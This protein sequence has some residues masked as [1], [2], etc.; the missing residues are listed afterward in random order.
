M[1]VEYCTRGR[2]MNQ[3]ASHSH[4]VWEIIVVEA[5]NIDMVIDDRTYK[6]GKSSVI[7]LPPNAIHSASSDTEFHDIFVQ[8]KNLDF[9]GVQIV[10]DTDNS[11]LTLMNLLN[12]VLLEAEKNYRNIA[13]ALMETICQYI[14]KLMNVNIKYG[15]A[16]QLKNTIF[17]GFSDAD[18]SIKKE[19]EK[20]GFQ[21]DYMRRCFKEETGRTPLEYLTYLRINLARNLLVQATFVSVEDVSR[22]CGFKDSYYFSTCFRKHTGVSPSRYRKQY[23]EL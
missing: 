5:G 4:A 23:R 1:N 10:Q 2:L 12:K 3:Y 14:Q 7:V 15:F 18:F 13:D 19:I 8:A 20:I 21:Q 17:E 6:V 16:E 11:I 9:Y 22:N